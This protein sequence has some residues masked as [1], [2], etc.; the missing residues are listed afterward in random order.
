M[1]T[2]HVYLLKD[3]SLPGKAYLRYDGNEN[4][5]IPIL[6][7]ADN[8]KAR[9]M[10][11]PARDPTRLFGDTPTGLYEACFDK[12][13]SPVATYGPYPVITMDPISGDALIAKQNGRAGLWVHG[14]N[15]TL[16]GLL[17]P[18]FGSLRTYNQDQEKL[19]Q[20]LGKEKFL[21][22]VLEVPALPA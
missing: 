5:Q 20:I 18:T 9:N 13:F 3:R 17:R 15:T 14:G 12:V 21:V 1:H 11:N 10:G 6:G 2:L 7:K 19:W 22:E 16:R 8:V 4:L